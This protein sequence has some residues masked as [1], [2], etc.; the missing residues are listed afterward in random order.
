M[1]S[2]HTLTIAAI[3]FLGVPHADA[4]SRQRVPPSSERGGGQ[5]RGSGQA[6]P[7]DGGAR[8]GGQEAAP[9]AS[10]PRDDANRGR[11]DGGARAETPRDGGGR[12]EV[13]P[14]PQAVQP[15][16]QAER[17]ATRDG[18]GAN[19]RERQAVPRD[20]GEYRGPV[21]GQAAGRDR[22]GSVYRG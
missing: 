19:D 11:Q 20:R 8:S 9:R 13:Q 6:A 17:R 7:R 4:Q 1:R 3:L 2:L 10:A 15:A 18:N 21:G 22:N 16:P 14:A 12:R 5:D